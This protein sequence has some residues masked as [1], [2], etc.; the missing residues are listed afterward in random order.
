M[1]KVLGLRRGAAD[2]ATPNAR[3]VRGGGATT[4]LHRRPSQ[5]FSRDG[6]AQTFP[7]PSGT[8]GASGSSDPA[9]LFG[10]SR[11]PRM[12]AHHPGLGKRITDYASGDVESYPTQPCFPPA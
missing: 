5:S 10:I 2:A 8:A 9:E 7:M 1:R 11:G 3:G 6:E 12:T 4:G